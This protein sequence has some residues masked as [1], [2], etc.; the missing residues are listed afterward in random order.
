MCN[1]TK[2]LNVKLYHLAI[3]VSLCWSVVWK[4]GPQSTTSVQ[5]KLVHLWFQEK[6]N[7][8][9]KLIKNNVELWCSMAP[10]GKKLPE[11]IRDIKKF[12]N[13]TH[14]SLL[15]K[16]CQE[17]TG[18]SF[19]RGTRSICEWCL[20]GEE[21]F[22][23]TMIQNTLE[24]FEFVKKNKMK[25]ITWLSLPPDLN[26]TEHFWSILKFLWFG[27]ILYMHMH[28]LYKYTCRLVVICYVKN[29][30]KFT[31]PHIQ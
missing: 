6:I 1:I 17:Q 16:P 20:V 14:N 5:Q 28:T 21:F 31:W 15:M 27:Y 3:G 19:W 26:P 7:F 25:T 23:I 22:N 9:N 18:K 12:N 29:L 4:Y 11:Q 13:A 10:H 30:M 8:M 24:K 2:I